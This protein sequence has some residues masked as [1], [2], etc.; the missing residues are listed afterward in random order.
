[1]AANTA[2]GER[3]G[4]WIVVLA[5]RPRS[6][7]V[8]AARTSAASAAVARPNQGSSKWIQVAPASSSAFASPASAS[9]TA[10]AA[11]MGSL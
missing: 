4:T 3:N 6:T 9:P 10:A 2:W 1:M 5:L 11:S 8:S 7:G